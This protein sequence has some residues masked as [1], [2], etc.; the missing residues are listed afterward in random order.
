MR[1]QAQRSTWYKM[2]TMQVDDLKMARRTTADCGYGF[3][4]LLA[5]ADPGA[6]L[7]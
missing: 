6:A 3:D 4:S 7:T 5:Q 1:S 2:L